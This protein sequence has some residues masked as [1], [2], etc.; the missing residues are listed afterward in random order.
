MTDWNNKKEVLEAV[1]ENG[2]ALEYASEELRADKEVV[3]AAILNDSRA[4]KFVNRSS[5]AINVLLEDEE[6]ELDEELIEI[7]EEA[8]YDPDC[9]IELLEYLQSDHDIWGLA[10]AVADNPNCTAQLLETMAD[11]WYDYSVLSA[12]AENPKC[13]EA[14]LVLLSEYEGNHGEEVHHAVA[15]NPN[16]PVSLLEVLAKDG[17]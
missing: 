15:R 10:T 7:A 17:G 14:T 11:E 1:S 16:C 8:A 6:D 2:D 5:L 9:S 4:L 3:Q 13:P 12:V